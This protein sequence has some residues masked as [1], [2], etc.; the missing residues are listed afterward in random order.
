MIY[1]PKCGTANRQG[2]KFCNECGTPLPATGLRCP[3][4][5]A[6]NPAGNLYCDR[7]NARLIPAEKT[8]PEEEKP[9]RPSPPKGISLP[10]VPLGEEGW[11]SELRA[12]AEAL[13]LLPE[14]EI[15]EWLAELEAPAAPPTPEAQPP[16]AAIPEWLAELEETVPE[17]PSPAEKTAPPLAGIPAPPSGE[18]PEWLRNIE[19]APPIQEEPSAQPPP[20][21]AVDVHAGAPPAVSTTVPPILIEEEDEG[22]LVTAPGEIP[23]WLKE[24]PEEAPPDFGG[25]VPAEIPEWLRALQPREEETVEEEPVETEGFLTGLRGLLSIG[26]GLDM[27]ATAQPSLPRAPSPAAVARAELLQGLL[28]RP[29]ITPPTAEAREALRQSGWIAARFLVGI[30]LL[31]AI[32]LPMLVRLS[33]FGPPTSTAAE[34]LFATVNQL[35]ENTPVLIAWEYGPAESDEMDRVAGPLMEHL[36]RQKARLII[37]STRLE[38]PAAAEALLTSRLADPSEWPRRIANLGYLPGQAAGVREAL[39]SLDG[40]T[41]ISTGQP[42][43]QAEAMA[44][45]HSVAD[46]GMVVVLA[47]QPDD[48]K[49]WLE[50]ISVARPDVPVVAG[51]SARTE[52]ISTPYLTA[53]QLKGMVAGLTGGAVYERQ[54]DT[55]RG[56]E[57]EYYLTSLGAAQLAIAALTIIGAL[58][59]LVGGR[60]R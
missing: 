33:L 4:C 7:C 36:L 42:A 49:T 41:E 8:P 43:S 51:V 34:T 54:L 28:S 59:F 53:G 21:A 46:V 24:A 56:R 58:I 26:K 48:L 57:Y 6:M 9:E 19:F 29:M 10:S 32:L 11:L 23:D 39:G 17:A 38:G 55:G 14:E 31:A 27:P 47:A 30:I 52:L 18:V 25:L 22:L 44:G 5:G 3:M 40:R 2:S 37:V 15:P 16:E 13:D 45:V 50:Q 60:K 12:E 1:C 20:I 35:S